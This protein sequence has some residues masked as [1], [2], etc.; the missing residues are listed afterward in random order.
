M[1]SALAAVTERIELA[2]FVSA[3]AF[4]NPA[5]TAKMAETVD[6]ISGGRF[7]LGLGSGWVEK[8]F[9]AFGFP[10]DHRAGRFEEALKIITSLVRTGRVDF[11][12]QFYSARDCELRPRGPRPEGMPIMVGTFLGERMMKLTAQYADEWNLWANSTGNRASGIPA[13]REKMDAICEQVGRDPKTLR[14]SVAVLVDTDG[15]YGRP[16]QDVPSLTGSPE[17]IA[18]ELF[19][20]AREGIDHVQLYPD[21]CTVAGFEV[22]AP[23]LEILDNG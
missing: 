17:A 16:G 8:E 13:L 22:L 1:L 18:E 2:P 12:G 11:E 3:T 6:E 5:L 15:A 14:R 9:S 7:I 21:P 10:F 4:R 23:V 20:Y 19:A